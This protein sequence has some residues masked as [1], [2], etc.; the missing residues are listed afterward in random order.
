VRQWLLAALGEKNCVQIV[1]SVAAN[2]R[3]SAQPVPFPLETV[4]A[5]GKFKGD[6]K[7]CD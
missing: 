7:Y 4:F 1:A 2:P 6:G 3:N 5:D